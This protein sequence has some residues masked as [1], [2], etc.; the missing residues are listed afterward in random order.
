VTEGPQAAV[1]ENLRPIVPF[2]FGVK[3]LLAAID[4]LVDSDLVTP[5]I[6][7]LYTTI[8]AMAWLALP[9]GRE[10]VKMGDFTGW[11]QRYELDRAVSPCTADELYGAR[12]GFVHSCNPE[13]TLSRAGS[14]REI[15]Y[16]RGYA[17][18]RMLQEEI[19]ALGKE[20]EAVALHLADF[21]RGLASAIEGFRGDIYTNKALWLRVARRSS[22]FLHSKIP[23]EYVRHF[24]TVASWITPGVDTSRSGDHAA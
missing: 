22:N 20:N 13:S 8:D 19:E 7:L 17:G 18:R 5:A 14:V 3:E 24:Q 23:D 9:D 10:T 21:R 1:P 4:L 11:V 16:M 15:V 12:C 6:T 2:E